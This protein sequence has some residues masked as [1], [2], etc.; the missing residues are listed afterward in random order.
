MDSGDRTPAVGGEREGA[1][2]VEHWKTVKGRKVMGD[3]V[4]REAGKMKQKTAFPGPLPGRWWASWGLDEE[5][6]SEEIGRH[7]GSRS[8]FAGCSCGG[9]TLAAGLSTG[10]P[11]VWMGSLSRLSKT[12]CTGSRY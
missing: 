8:R 11:T 9:G 5:I 2:R 3:Y 12:A 6:V 1:V 10:A 7:G 4:W